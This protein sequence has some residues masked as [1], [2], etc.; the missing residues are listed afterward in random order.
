MKRK[1]PEKRETTHYGLFCTI[2][3]ERYIGC[4]IQEMQTRWTEHFDRM[5]CLDTKIAKA[6]RKHGAANWEVRILHKGE[7]TKEESRQMERK[8]QKEYQAFDP[9]IGLNMRRGGGTAALRKE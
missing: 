6:M 7:M 9:V 5:Y 1:L 8:F 4:T 3:P 2:T